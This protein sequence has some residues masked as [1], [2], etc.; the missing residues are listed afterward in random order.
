[1]GKITWATLVVFALLLTVS[2]TRAQ[3]IDRLVIRIAQAELLPGGY[4][5]VRYAASV[6]AVDTQG[7][8]VSVATF[9]GVS[10]ASEREITWL[11]GAP[12]ADVAVGAG[13]ATVRGLSDGFLAGADARLLVFA[14]AAGV[15]DV[16]EVP[17]SGLHGQLYR[18][19]RGSTF[20]R[21]CFPP[22]LCPVFSTEELRGTYATHYS[23]I[24]RLMTSTGR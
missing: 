7:Q 6:E 3:E 2:L 20:S 1:M 22:C 23:T 18:L 15:F 13:V 8:R 9:L 19:E 14:F 12:W 21:G 24:T 4:D 11:S 17:L 10:V 5:R 16:V